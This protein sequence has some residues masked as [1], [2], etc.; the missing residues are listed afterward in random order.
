MQI[1]PN[2]LYLWTL[3][4]FPL[5]TAIFYPI[6]NSQQRVFLI[7]LMMTGL[8]LQGLP[9]LLGIL[10]LKITVTDSELTYKG[11]L[12]TKIVNVKDLTSVTDRQLFNWLRTTTF[13]INEKPSFVIW[14]NPGF[15]MKEINQLFEKLKQINPNIS[16]RSIGGSSKVS[17][18]YNF[19]K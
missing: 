2:M 19:S 3:T 12:V 1:R 5:I 18:Y 7:L 15:S 16:T 14:N 10:L 17:D 11:Y 6:L 13:F 8:L 9:I 4:V